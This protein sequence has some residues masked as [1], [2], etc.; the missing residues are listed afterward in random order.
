MQ[1]S[2]QMVAHIGLVWIKI[3][4]A[5]S[6]FGYWEHGFLIKMIIFYIYEFNKHST[7]NCGSSRVLGLTQH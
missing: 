4:G 3:S 2:R 5:T 7:E 1:L 6:G